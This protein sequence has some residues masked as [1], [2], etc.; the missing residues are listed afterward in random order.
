M[1]DKRELDL[2]EEEYK[3]IGL[4]ELT[5]DIVCDID[6]IRSRADRLAEIE[7]EVGQSICSSW[8]S[9]I[10]KEAKKHGYASGKTYEEY[11]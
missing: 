8:Y 2:L 7:E 11:Y 9:D 6:I 5:D 10:E 4:A 3:R 1:I